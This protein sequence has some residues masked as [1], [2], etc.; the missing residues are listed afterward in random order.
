MKQHRK[1]SSFTDAHVIG[2]DLSAPEPS[3]DVQ[4]DGVFLR[5]AGYCE[6]LH[7][8]TRISLRDIRW[9][10]R[11]SSPDQGHSIAPWASR[12]ARKSGVVIKYEPCRLQHN[13]ITLHHQS[14]DQ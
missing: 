8:T 3:P 1:T 12:H 14:F 6:T 11:G 9:P 7:V 13:S 10:G 2:N 5:P 4:L